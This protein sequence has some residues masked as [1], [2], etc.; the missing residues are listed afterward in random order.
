MSEQN[1]TQNMLNAI[2]GVLIICFFIGI[3]VL[4]IWVVLV[5]GLPDRAWQL[6]AKLFDLSAEQ[7]VL[8][9]YIGI[10]MT[11]SVIFV[12]FLFPYIGIKLT[13]RKKAQRNPVL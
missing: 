3:G 10:L 7:V 9:Q 1:N 6:H 2:A 5:M 12:L 4:T 11:K 8:S 13:I